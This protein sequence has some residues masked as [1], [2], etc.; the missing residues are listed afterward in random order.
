MLCLPFSFTSFFAFSFP[1]SLPFSFPLK[2]APIGRRGGKD[3]ELD[4]LDFEEVVA[5]DSAVVVVNA[6]A[7]SA[8]F[9]FLLILSLALASGVEVWKMWRPDESFDFVNIRNCGVCAS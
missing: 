7:F 1:F 5:Q 2:Q 8:A 4:G 6:L 3:V 9:C